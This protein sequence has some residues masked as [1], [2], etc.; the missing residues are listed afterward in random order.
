MDRAADDKFNYYVQRGANRENFRGGRGR[1]PALEEFGMFLKRLS[2]DYKVYVLLDNPSSRGFD[3]GAIFGDGGNRRSLTFSLVATGETGMSPKPF[4]RDERQVALEDEMR[5]LV[6]SS[7]AIA[8]EQ[9]ESICPK[10]ICSPMDAE[11]RP[12]YKDR[13]HIRPFYIRAAMTAMDVTLLR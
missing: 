10:G 3:P 4:Q 8:L 13:H 11:A 2:K 1:D 5:Q 6:H 12:I 9:S 7:G